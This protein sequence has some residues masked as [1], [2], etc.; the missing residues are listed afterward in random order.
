MN[1]RSFAVLF[2]FFLLL[3]GLTVL[4][5]LFFSGEEK[6]VVG[7]EDGGVVIDDFGLSTISPI[8]STP[9]QI[10]FD[11]VDSY[12]GGD[13]GV[14]DDR[15]Y[16]V[17]PADSGSATVSPSEESR[18]VRLFAGPTAGYRI[19]KDGDEWVVRAVEGGKGGRYIIRTAP[20]SLNFVA[21]GEFTKVIESH[22]FSNDLALMLYESSD[23]ESIVRSAF[24]PF[25]PPDGTGKIQRFEKNIRVATDNET[26]L[27]FTQMVGEKVV[28]LVVDVESPEDTEVVWESVFTNW[29]PR[30]GRNSHI[31]LAGPITEALDGYVYLI[32]PDGDDP[33]NRFVDIP[34]GGSAFIDTSSGFFVLHTMTNES[35]AGKTIITDQARDVVIDIPITLPEK[36]DGFNGVF[37]CAVPETIPANTSSGYETVFPDSWYQ[38]DISF[39]DSVVLIDAVSGD[40]RLILSPRQP[41]FA[42][43]SDGDVFDIIHPHISEDGQFLF[44]VNKRDLSLWMLRL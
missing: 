41:D 6:N 16:T 8:P 18:L 33:L 32:D 31:T 11:D 37:V 26:R 34:S 24:V 12:T 1:I 25:A 29:T 5:F 3:V 22:I 43:L 27:F 14:R 21:P 44:F 9:Q 30:W 7:G 40:R 38:G 13:G 42:E 39:N 23:V 15:V 36:C 17:L 2:V 35:F 20:Y 10:V 19:D 4:Y 28:G